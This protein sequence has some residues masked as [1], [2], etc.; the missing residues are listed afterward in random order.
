MK[1]THTSNLS[2]ET[3]IFFIKEKN[4]KNIIMMYQIDQVDQLQACW[5]NEQQ[6]QKNAIDSKQQQQL[7]G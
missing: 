6:Q 5:V 1:T 3:E 2:C 4:K 7:K